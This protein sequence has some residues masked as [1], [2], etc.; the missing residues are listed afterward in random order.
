MMLFSFRVRNFGKSGQTSGFSELLHPILAVRIVTAWLFSN[1][2]FSNRLLSM[3]SGSYHGGKERQ[4]QKC[5]NSFFLR[6]HR[7]YFYH[8]LGQSH[9]T[10]YPSTGRHYSY[11]AV[12]WLQ[13]TFTYSAINKIVSHDIEKSFRSFVL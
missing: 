9:T 5:P 6:L 2:S 8:H 4:L 1:R 10:T 12:A 3:Q 13:G 7:S 11:T